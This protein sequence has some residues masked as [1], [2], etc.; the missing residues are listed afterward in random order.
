M[1]NICKIH[2]LT[3]F[4]V[5]LFILLG[6]FKFYLYFMLV[7]LIHELGHLTFALIFRW[8]VKNITILPLG[9]LI[10]FENNLNKPIK[11]E[12][13]IAI[14]GIVFQ[15][16]LILIVH[17]EML[18]M[19]YKIVLIFNLIPIYPLDGAKIINLIL[20]KI[21]S[22]KK[23]YLISLEISYIIV[24]LLLF[25]SIINASLFM[26]VIMI[27]LLFSTINLIAKRK[28]IYM[29]FLLERYLYKFK[30]KKYKYVVSSDKMKRDYKHY[31]IINDKIISEDEYLE[32]FFGKKIGY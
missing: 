22:F 8:K 6:Y 17:N 30:F 3:Y 1:K 27:P 7:I 12:F 9:A 10:K 15:S 2:P 25:F 24:I 4:F 26:M 13:I 28:D 29:K 18:V 31:F 19:C 20:N 23:S 32:K 11:E 16:V 21:I 5:L 14:M